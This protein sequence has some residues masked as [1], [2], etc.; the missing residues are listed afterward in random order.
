MPDS[1]ERSCASRDSVRSIGAT[2]RIGVR[3]NFAFVAMFARRL[4]LAQPLASCATTRCVLLF[5][6]GSAHF[7][8][9]AFHSVLASTR[10]SLARVE[11]ACFPAKKEATMDLLS[12]L[13]NRS[14][15]SR[16]QLQFI[17]GA[18]ALSGLCEKKTKGQRKLERCACALG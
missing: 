1:F 8:R 2:D 9:Q 15:Y 7:G 11:R 3:G 18:W 6:I 12:A 5:F 16:H 10:N 13:S 4:A 14:D 17:V